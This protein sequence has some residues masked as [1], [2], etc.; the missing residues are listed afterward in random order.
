MRY[1]IVAVGHKS[2]KSFV[3]GVSILIANSTFLAF[4]CWYER[5]LRGHNTQ[6]ISTKEDVE[7]I[8]FLFL[9]CFS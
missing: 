8:V 6:T 5:K 2:L 4:A 9:D 1:I 3:S 7:G